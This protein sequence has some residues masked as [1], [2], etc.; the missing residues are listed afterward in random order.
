M[1][2]TY[3]YTCG[4][5]TDQP[6][7]RRPCTYH[8]CRQCGVR[9]NVVSIWRACE[10]CGQWLIL[11]PK[12]AK[13]KR[14]KACQRKRNLVKVAAWWKMNWEAERRRNAAD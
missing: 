8:V 9:V 2:T 13:V 7:I 3:F 1:T 6:D 5:S 4:H 12:Q 11:G 10:D 14:C